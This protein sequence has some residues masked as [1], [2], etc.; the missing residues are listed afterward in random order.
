MRNSDMSGLRNAQVLWMV[1]ALLAMGCEPTGERGGR[2]AGS[3]ASDPSGDMVLIPGGE[4]TMGSD[5][6]GDHAPA[7]RV[8]LR[9]FYI[10]MYEVTNAEYFEFCQAT[11]HRL[12]EFWGEDVRRSGPEYP[13]HP[14]TGISWRDATEYA[15][16][17]GMRLPTEAEWELAARGG[18][19]GRHYPTLEAPSV[20]RWTWAVIPR[21][22]LECTTWLA[23]CS[24][25]SRT[26][27]ART[28]TLPG[29]SRIHLGPSPGSSG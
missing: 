26:G 10:G 4:F 22:G 19:A 2:S 25:G 17:R 5:T 12:P 14:V 21:T 18:I 24:S 20:A 7:H 28:I 23:M 3:A 27:T 15:E 6:D 1:L 9:A 29:R 11:G 8:M 16:W 13:N